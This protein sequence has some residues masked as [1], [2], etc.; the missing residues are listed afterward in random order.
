M[1]CVFLYAL[2]FSKEDSEMKN[3][4]KSQWS[5]AVMAIATVAGMTVA[6]SGGGS[7]TSP[8]SPTPPP[9]TTTPPP[10]SGGYTAQEKSDMVNAYLL[11]QGPMAMTS[12][13]A[14]AP[15]RLTSWS[16]NVKDIEVIISPS[17]NDANRQAI[18]DTFDQ[19]NQARGGIF[20]IRQTIADVQGNPP[21]GKI[22]VR[23]QSSIAEICSSPTNIGCV[24]NKI[25]VDSNNF[26]SAVINLRTDASPHHAAHEANH[27][28]IGG[29][30]VPSGTLVAP[31]TVMGSATTPKLTDWE[32]GILKE[33]FLEKGLRPGATG[34]DFAQVGIT[35]NSNNTTSAAQSISPGGSPSWFISA[36]PGRN[37]VLAM[38]TPGR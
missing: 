2:T 38:V 20:N 11:G 7:P 31:N 16:E 17:T 37:P 3:L 26:G 34:A 4:L 15:N 32:F 19:Y 24:S 21:V 1:P 9:T 18:S 25:M 6:C 29:C 27:A 35:L 5:N 28:V 30:H 33:V 12:N 36:P 10:T 22:Y 13:V 8:T 23:T 14:C